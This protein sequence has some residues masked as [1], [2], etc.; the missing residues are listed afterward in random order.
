ME[1]KSYELFYKI[2]LHLWYEK[3]KLKNWK[4]K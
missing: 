2:I 1:M 4:K 3:Y